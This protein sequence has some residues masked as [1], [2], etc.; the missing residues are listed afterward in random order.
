MAQFE[1][2]FSQDFTDDIIIRHRENVMF[3][4]DNNGAIV[5]V[6]LFNDG[7]AYSGGGTVTG[8]VV[9][10]DGGRVVLT[11]TLS[12]NAASVVIPGAALA[13]AGPIG[14]QI[15]L[16]A[17]G[18]KATVLKVIYSV[19][20]TSGTPVDPGD[21]VPDIDELLAEIETMR[22]A[23]AAA[24]TAAQTASMA[25]S[26]TDFVKFSDLV[27][28]SNMVQYGEMQID[29]YISVP[30][31]AL[32][33]NSRFITYTNIP[34]VAGRRYS[35][36]IPSGGRIGWYR[37]DNTCISAVA[38]NGTQQYETAANDAAY[39]CV[40]Y[41]KIAAF[42]PAIY[43]VTNTTLQDAQ[44]EVLALRGNVVVPLE[45]VHK[46]ITIGK[47]LFNPNDVNPY[48]GLLTGYAYN[49]NLNTWRSNI[50]F[51]PIKPNTQYISNVNNIYV[52]VY[53]ADYNFIQAYNMQALDHTFTST[54]NAAYIRCAW[55]S[56]F[57]PDDIAAQQLEE[58]SVNTKFEPF[59]YKIND[60]YA[61]LNRTI[62]V[63]AAGSG[64]FCTITDA[65]NASNDGDTIYIKNG[66][67]TES[68]KLNTRRVRFIGESMDGTILQY[69]GAARAN[70]PMDI[71]HGYVEN[72]TIR[73]TG[74]IPETGI[75][76]YAVHIDSAESK[77]QTLEFKHVKFTSSVWQVVGIGLYPHFVLRFTD[78][79]FISENAQEA[80]YCHDCGPD[81]YTDYTGQELILD[82]CRF[83]T[84]NTSGTIHFQSQER[85]GAVA[86]ATLI[87]NAVIGTRPIIM[88]QWGTPIGGNHFLG[89]SDWYLA[90]ISMQNNVASMNY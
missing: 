16:T 69:S 90:P 50:K 65:V 34:V 51:Y 80:F 81:N 79:W 77:D 19:D 11:G 60:D 63:D 64:D 17:G 86:T 26:H 5:G 58:G 49:T 61:M 68:L 78:C 1:Q 75:P 10:S 54:A 52:N 18:Q 71:S 25:A 22:Q 85:S 73:A 27:N 39:V 72:M 88:T 4:G 33:T 47:N 2:W 42:A 24:N 83:V 70:A 57:P 40:C 9:R 6:R 43:E 7:A 84:E 67:Y 76:A 38:S 55:N 56:A 59:R 20:Y 28:C 3:S 82:S 41:E 44:D 15:I 89:A 31:G 36:L 8:A 45:S 21:L 62:T 53:D 87:N 13:Y 74:T 32:N 46:Y 37:S 48:S 35:Y 66:V 14:V 12:G 23:T 29:K 30:D